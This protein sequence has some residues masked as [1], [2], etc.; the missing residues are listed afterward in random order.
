VEAVDKQKTRRDRIIQ[1]AR[2]E[3]ST[4]GLAG[5]R[6]ARI[7]ERAR[8]NKQLIFYYFGT[9]RGLYNAV[10]T[11]AGGELTAPSKG[12]DSTESRGPAERIRQTLRS[13]YGTL[14]G[15]PELAGLLVRG[16]S[17][18]AGSGQSLARF[19]R[20][21]TA[22]LSGVISEGQGLGYFRD[23]LD[24]D[25]AARLIVVAALGYLALERSLASGSP[26]QQRAKWLEQSCDLLLRSLSW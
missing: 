3:F 7:A 2:E 4:V 1:A 22:D 10:L 8:V 16:V 18:P 9:K 20:D 26:E 23:D 12:D 25:F 13:V 11:G 5:A 17:D 24:P 21:L 6:T 14:A 15:K 19:L